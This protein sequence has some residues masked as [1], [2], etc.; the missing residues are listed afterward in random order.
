M[1]ESNNIETS[2]LEQDMNGKAL[3]KVDEVGK[4]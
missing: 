4:W 1:P 3:I 2:F